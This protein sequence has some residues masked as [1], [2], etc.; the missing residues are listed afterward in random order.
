MQVP[1]INTAI[2]C[3]KKEQNSKLWSYPY[4][5]VD[6]S[7]IEVILSSIGGHQSL[8]VTWLSAGWGHKYNLG[9]VWTAHNLQSWARQGIHLSINV[10]RD[11][12]HTTSVIC[13]IRTIRS[14]KRVMNWQ[15]LL[16]TN[17]CG[18]FLMMILIWNTDHFSITGSSK[19]DVK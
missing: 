19:K 4:L 1:I 5:A 7:P 9:C 14:M 8:S 15:M 2:H 3:Q 13:R 16:I 6:C 11:P 18:Y 17:I 10:H 12:G